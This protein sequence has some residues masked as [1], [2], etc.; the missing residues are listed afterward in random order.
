MGL[1]PRW[2]PGSSLL[3]KPQRLLLYVGGLLWG[4][5][6]VTW[7]LY[8][9]YVSWL[10]H[11][12]GPTVYQAASQAG[13]TA[14]EQH[15]QNPLGGRG[16]TIRNPHG[17]QGQAEAPHHSD[18]MAGCAQGSKFSVNLEKRPLRRGGDVCMAQRSQA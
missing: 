2:D 5:Y 14:V 13:G 3:F 4:A 17:G 16:A 12:C 10:P 6:K 11:N 7:R 8:M 1:A 18:Q 9:P 15:Q